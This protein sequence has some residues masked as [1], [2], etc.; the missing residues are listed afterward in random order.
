MAVFLKKSRGFHVLFLRDFRSIEVIQ[1]FIRTSFPNGFLRAGFG[2]SADFRADS[3]Q[4]CQLFVSEIRFPDEHVTVGPDSAD[5][6][7]PVFLVPLSVPG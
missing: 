6:I 4:H 5:K 2:T 1:L 3:E 7:Y